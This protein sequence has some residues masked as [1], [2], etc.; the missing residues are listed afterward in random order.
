[1]QKQIPNEL[2]ARFSTIEGRKELIEKY[3]DSD[4]MYVGEN[5]DGEMVAISIDRERGIVLKTNQENG[6][7]RVN[8]YDKD[9]I[10]EGESF[11]GKWR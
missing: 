3:G 4:T 11:D 5:E 6:W 10:G 9:G 8:Y 1:M 7:V 2:S